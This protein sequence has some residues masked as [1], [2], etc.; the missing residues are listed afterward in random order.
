V[1]GAWLFDD[2]AKETY[3]SGG[4]GP[5][6]CQLQAYQLPSLLVPA[7]PGWAET[8][9]EKGARPASLNVQLTAS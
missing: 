8:E 3:Q 5:G 7:P 6:A 9:N 4:G 1:N 2:V